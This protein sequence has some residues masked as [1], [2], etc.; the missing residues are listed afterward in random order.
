VGKSQLLHWTRQ[1]LNSPIGYATQP[2]WN[3]G[4]FVTPQKSQREKLYRASLKREE[5]VVDVEN[6]RPRQLITSYRL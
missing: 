4:K 2:S 3:N 1:N 5:K 6:N